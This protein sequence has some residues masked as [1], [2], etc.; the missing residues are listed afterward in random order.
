M[1]I[2]ILTSYTGKQKYKPDNRI[3]S[4]D[5]S[6]PEHLEVRIRELCGY[7]SE[8]EY[9]ESGDYS[10]RAGEMF[11]GPS[12][13]QVQAG[14][15]QIR[16]HEAYGENI[17]DQYFPSHY[18]R[19]DGGDDL[20]HEDDY[21]VPFDILPIHGPSSSYYGE[22]D[23]VDR[24]K[25]LI[26][27]YDLVFS[28]MEKYHVSPLISLFESRCA[29]T[30]ILMA[31]PSWGISIPASS[32]NTHLVCTGADLVGRLDG[33][34]RHNLRGAAFRKLCEVACQEGFHV[35]EEVKQDPQRLREIVL[36]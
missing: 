29:R 25:V 10:V 32:L 11:T 4:E 28:L 20:V 26:R 18:Y 23:T 22:T 13:K 6:P 33:A 19:V 36:R 31:A 17:I 16:N 15:K 30:L 34:S 9:D 2:L 12:H 8:G 1:K 3:R 24:L 21:I 14:L 35:F 27:R 5:L 7:N